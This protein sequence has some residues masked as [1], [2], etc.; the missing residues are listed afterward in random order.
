MRPR[1]ATPN[2]I[3]GMAASSENICLARFQPQ[4]ITTK[5]SGNYCDYCSQFCRA[6]TKKEICHVL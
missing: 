6:E 3:I 5:T 2:Q 4:T 1:F